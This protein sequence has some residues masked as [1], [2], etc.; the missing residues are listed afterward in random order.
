MGRQGRGRRLTDRERLEIIE[1]ARQHPEVK[2]VELAATY[3]V[4]ESTIRKWRRET[5]ATKVRARC[6]S[7]GSHDRRRGQAERARQFD[8]QLF[9]W[10]CAARNRGENL[11]PIQ[12]RAKARALA[13]TYEQMGNFKASSGWY[14]RYCR[15]F[16]LTAASS[17]IS[18]DSA[19]PSSNSSDVDDGTAATTAAPEFAGLEPVTTATVSGM[20]SLESSPPS[21]LNGNKDVDVTASAAPTETPSLSRVHVHEAED[22]AAACQAAI[23][24][25]LHHHTALLSRAS[26][27][28]FIQYLAD[29]PEELKAFAHMSSSERVQYA[30]SFANSASHDAPKQR[31]Y[32][33]RAA[34]V[35]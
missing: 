26:R 23:A 9:N 1:F 29:V 17:S 19:N 5:N 34:R 8:L 4:N 6:A 3:H 13:M 10:I 28:R 27:S 14:Y 7:S 32:Q 11:R 33:Y 25:F 22:G 16:G 15:R 35:L 12:V 31:N 30:K 21:E 2:H 18:E 24:H 20:F